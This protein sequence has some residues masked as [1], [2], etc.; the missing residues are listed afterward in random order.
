VRVE[1][2]DDIG[3]AAG[4]IVAAGIRAAIAR[5]GVCRLA[6]PGGS[7]PVG[8]FRWLAEHL[9]ARDVV[10]TWVDERHVP[11]DGDD[12]RAWSPDS[13][14]RLAWEHWLSRVEARPRE[15][16]LDA[17]GS[18]DHA[19]TVVRERFVAEVGKL[20]VVVLGA[21]PDGHVASLFPGRPDQPGPVFAVRDSPKP[22]P[23]RLTL[24]RAVLEDTELAVL[25]AGG[26]EKRPILQRAAAGDASIPLGALRPR[27]EWVWVV[28]RASW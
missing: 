27:G 18:L 24:S 17:P 1:V 19:L 5:N 25:V 15:I 23:E 22:P 20:D 21:G 8:L 2:A 3:A 6:V 14:R 10:L 26:A 7:G 12:W 9:D 13:N 4:P 16:P 11:Q 28:D